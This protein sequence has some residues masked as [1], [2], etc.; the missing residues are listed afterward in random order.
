MY[1]YLLETKSKEEADKYLDLYQDDINKAIGLERA[2]K[3]I[4][5]LD[6]DFSKIIREDG[7]LMDDTDIKKYILKKLNIKIQNY[8][9][10][11][12][13]YLG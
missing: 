4:D 9:K 10:R 3:F 1:N 11:Q 8:L 7:S 6:K 12:C 13:I 2:N 5:Q